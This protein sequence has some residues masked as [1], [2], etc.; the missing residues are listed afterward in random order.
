MD[1]RLVCFLIEEVE[2]DPGELMVFEVE[3]RNTVFSGFKH[4]TVPFVHHSEGVHDLFEDVLEQDLAIGV[5][6]DDTVLSVSSHSHEAVGVVE[7][8]VEV[9]HFLVLLLEFDGLWV[10]KEH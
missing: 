10:G 6:V 3:N 1:E 7:G 4:D 5:E 9:K 2:G 8:C